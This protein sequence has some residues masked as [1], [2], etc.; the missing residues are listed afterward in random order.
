MKRI[1]DNRK[2]NIVIIGGSHSGFSAAIMLTKGPSTMLRNTSVKPS[3]QF[4]YLETGQFKFPGAQLKSVENC[5]RCCTCAYLKKE[6]LM[7]KA[8][9]CSCVC[10]CFGFFKYSEWGFDYNSIPQWSDGSIK[11]L[12]RDKI[13]VF[14]NQVRAAEADGYGEFKKTCFTNKSGYLYSFTGL[15]GDAKRLYKSITKGEEKRVRLILAPTP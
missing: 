10:R 9:K 11:I 5:G 8:D 4:R 6:N 2:R 12:Y 14:Y 7:D 13:K 3:V 1:I 15:R